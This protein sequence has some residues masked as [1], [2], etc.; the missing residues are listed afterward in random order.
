M[1]DTHS[2]PYGSKLW[3]F[4]SWK[5]LFLQRDTISAQATMNFF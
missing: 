3:F 5:N 2:I 4:Q 1:C